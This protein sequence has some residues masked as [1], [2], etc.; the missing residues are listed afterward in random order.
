MT[1][2]PQDN[3]PALGSVENWIQS[4]PA[5]DIT[6]ELSVVIPAYNEERRLPPALVDIID[7][8]DSTLKTYEILVVEDGSHDNTADI[9]R[10]FERLRPQV[11]LIS[12]PDNRGKG[13]AVRTGV[14]NARGKLILFADADGATPI[15]EYLRLKQA[16][17]SGADIAFA[18]RAL[19]SEST[20]VKTSWYRK[21]PG[22]IFNYAVNTLLL[23]G[24]ADTQCG[25]KLFRGPAARFVFSQQTANRYSFDVEILYLARL[26]GLRSSEVPVNWTN[27]PGSKV[28]LLLDSISMLIDVCKF[29]FLHRQINPEVFAEFLRKENA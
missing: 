17:D 2:A 13:H 10:K 7:F 21:Y 15:E 19:Q 22:R 5:A 3:E 29:K 6:V 4:Q 18:S 9:V 27:I 20:K 23:A 14:V 28:N 8:C 1:A 24:V 16:I 12:L 11:R 26:A 25:F